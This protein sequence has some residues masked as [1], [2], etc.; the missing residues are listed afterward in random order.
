MDCQRCTPHE[1][2]YTTRTRWSHHGRPRAVLGGAPRMARG[3]EAWPWRVGL[4]GHPESE[5]FCSHIFGAVPACV[6]CVWLQAGQA[7]GEGQACRIVESHGN[8]SAAAVDESICTNHECYDLFIAWCLWR[9]VGFNLDLD[10]VT[11]EAP[12]RAPTY[13]PPPVAV[14]KFDPR[15]RVASTAPTFIHTTPPCPGMLNLCPSTLR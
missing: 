8:A 15:T 14:G 7:I 12:G 3:D 2:G 5:L 9:C 4:A 11:W 1:V 13:V 6:C 10:A